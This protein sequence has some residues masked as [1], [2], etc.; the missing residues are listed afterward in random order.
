MKNFIETALKNSRNNLVKK[1]MKNQMLKLASQG[2]GS[3]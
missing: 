3:M 2:E 1:S